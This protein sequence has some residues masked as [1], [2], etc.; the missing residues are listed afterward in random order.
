MSCRRL[1]FPSLL[2]FQSPP[3]QTTRRGA[4]CNVAARRTRTGPGGLVVLDIHDEE[5]EEDMRCIPQSVTR[6]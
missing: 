5:E 1:R 4:W 2:N 6:S 3:E